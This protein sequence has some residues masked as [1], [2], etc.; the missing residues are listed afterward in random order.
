[1]IVICEQNN[2]KKCLENACYQRDV[3]IRL[4][5]CQSKQL[6]KKI[7]PSDATTLL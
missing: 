5:N 1:M 7:L 4:E 6:Y 3:A 2:F